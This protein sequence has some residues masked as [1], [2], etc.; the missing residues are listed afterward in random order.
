MCQA[1][2]LSYLTPI[3]VPALSNSRGAPRH[4]GLLFSL[5]P[6]SWNT[7]GL[8]WVQAG[9]VSGPNKDQV[10]PEVRGSEQN[11]H[12]L[13]REGRNQCRTHVSSRACS[14]PAASWVVGS[15]GQK[16]MD[17]RGLMEELVELDTCWCHDALVALLLCRHRASTNPRVRNGAACLLLQ[18]L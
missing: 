2:G 9:A 13:Q 10:R 17:R 7:G 4:C 18:L 16:G 5:A 3:H 11:N 14:I 8:H 6:I 15:A 12:N 1:L